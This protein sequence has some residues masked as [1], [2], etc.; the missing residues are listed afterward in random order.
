MVERLPAVAPVGR[1][2]LAAHASERMP[3]TFLAAGVGVGD[4]LDPVR[5]V[6][7]L[8]ALGEELQHLSPCFFDALGRDCDRDA[9][10]DV[11][12]KALF[13]LSKNP[14]PAR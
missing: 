13:S 7:F 1:N 9:P 5:S 2:I 12:R 14:S 10:Q 8:E 11:Q 3:E 4:E 6:D